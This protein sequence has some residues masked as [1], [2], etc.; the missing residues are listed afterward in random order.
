VRRFTHTHAW[1]LIWLTVFD[2]VIVYLTWKEYQEQ[3]AKRSEK[4][5]TP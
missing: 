2:A 4:I 5:A 1:A 3:K